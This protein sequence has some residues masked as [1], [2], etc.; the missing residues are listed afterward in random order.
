ASHLQWSS[1]H[2]A[3]PEGDLWRR[4][5]GGG[6]HLDPVDADFADPPGTGAEHE[7][8]S[9]AG[10]VDHLLVQFADAGP[11]GKH[12]SV[13]TPVG[14]GARIGDGELTGTGSGGGDA[15]AAVPVDPGAQFGEEVGRVAA[16]QHVE[17]G[18]ED[19]SGE[20]GV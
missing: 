5:T 13:E 3:V 17:N 7:H 8:V 10:F 19:R 6:N 18:I 11:V 9:L 14:D 4:F 2:V 15:G 12:D 16:R 20:L 1:R